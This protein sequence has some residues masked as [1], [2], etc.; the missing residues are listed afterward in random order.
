TCNNMY[1]SKSVWPSCAFIFSMAFVLAFISQP[2]MAQQ[3]NFGLAEQFTTQMMSK[4]TGSTSVYPRW[5]EDQNRFWYTYETAEG[6][7]WYM[8]DAEK[9]KK[10]LLFDQ[11]EMAAK[12]S[13]I[14]NKP[15][16]STD[17]PLKN[18]KYDVEKELFTFHVD[19]INFKY[20]LENN[21]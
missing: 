17:L 2:V 8:V 11:E 6:K 15:F 7:N 10:R 9:A 16:N 14:F 20:K 4:M 13:E 21:Q 3:A 12:L 5:I 1:M 18:F 19:S